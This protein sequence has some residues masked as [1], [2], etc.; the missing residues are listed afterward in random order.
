MQ[1]R[2]V[3]TLYEEHVWLRSIYRTKTAISRS[4][5]AQRFELQ[6]YR[7]GD[8]VVISDQLIALGTGAS[9]HDLNSLTVP[10]HLHGGLSEQKVYLLFNCRLLNLSVE[11]RWRSF[12]I[13]DL[14]L[15]HVCITT[16]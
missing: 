13:F 16:S 9:D 10:L 6:P 3:G 7:I 14:A 5:A 1:L 11:H 4:K 8:L 15:N 2:P 12:D